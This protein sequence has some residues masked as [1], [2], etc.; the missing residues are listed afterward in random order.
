[1]LWISPKFKNL[2]QISESW[3]NFRNLILVKFQNFE[4]ISECQPNFRI[5]TKFQNL[6]QISESWPNFRIS[7]QFQNL[8]PISESRPNFRISTKFQDFDQISG[9]QPNL[10][11][12]TPPFP[13]LLFHMEIDQACLFQSVSILSGCVMKYKLSARTLPHY[14]L[15]FWYR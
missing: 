14:F 3:P 15:Q 2:D 4:Q 6:D 1:M 10:R 8:D 11:M 7:T 13:T 12:S 5:W 9:F